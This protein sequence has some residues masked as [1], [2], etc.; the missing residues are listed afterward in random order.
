MQPPPEMAE[1]IYS[2]ALP[3]A[4]SIWIIVGPVLLL[5]LL[6]V[7]ISVFAG[8]QEPP[9]EDGWNGIFYSNPDD[10]ALFVPKRRGIGYTLNFSNPWSWVVLAL[11][12]VMIAAPL[13]LSF[14]VVPHLK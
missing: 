12:L 9:P 3:T 2:S 14:A 6:A 13:V 11:I 8:G 10:P 4:P 1:Q 7:L 5:G